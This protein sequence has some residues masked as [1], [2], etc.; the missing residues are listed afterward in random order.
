MV[1]IEKFTYSIATAATAA[2]ATAAAITI[3]ILIY[4][5]RDRKSLPPLDEASAQFIAQRFVEG[6]MHR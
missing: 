3:T 4:K 2:I 1:E 6:S 5:T